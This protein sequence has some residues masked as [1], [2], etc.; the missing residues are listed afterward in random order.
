MPRRRLVGLAGALLAWLLAW[1]LRHQFHAGVK[2]CRRALV[3]GQPWP[4][5]ARATAWSF[6]AEAA[7]RPGPHGPVTQTP[8]ALDQ[9]P[10]LL[11]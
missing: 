3:A 5:P 8:R 7:A 6:Q 11:P 1:R 10:R 4:L 2:A 9:L